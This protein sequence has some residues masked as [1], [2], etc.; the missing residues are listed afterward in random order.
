MDVAKR[1]QTTVTVTKF[2]SKND[3]IYVSQGV[4]VGNRKSDAFSLPRNHTQNDILHLNALQLPIACDIVFDQGFIISEI[5]GYV[6]GL[7]RE[8]L[9]SSS[10]SEGEIWP[11]LTLLL[12]FD[13]GSELKH[14]I[15]LDELTLRRTRAFLEALNDSDSP[16]PFLLFMI[17]SLNKS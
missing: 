6:L 1:Y 17:N 15:E 4:R 14:L 11:K 3:A 2:D 8:S 12:S 13:N 5:G 9:S 16:D 10:S 7:G